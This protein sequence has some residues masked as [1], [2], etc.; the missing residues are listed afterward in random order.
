MPLNI[1]FD[2]NGKPKLNSEQLKYAR[3]IGEKAK[4]MGVPP[5]FAIAIAF[6]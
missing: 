2:A 1:L 6:K 4:E 3:K 5:D